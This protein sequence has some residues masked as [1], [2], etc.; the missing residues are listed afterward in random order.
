MKRI[1]LLAAIKSE[2]PDCIPY[3]RSNS[4][5]NFRIGQNDIGVLLSGVGPEK[6][7]KTTE[8]LCA[9]FK[10]DLII[11]LGFCG[12]IDPEL[13]I[14]TL[15]VADTIYYQGKKEPLDCSVSGDVKRCL[16]NSSTD[17]ITGRFQTFDHPVLSRKEVLEGVLGVDMEAYAICKMAQKFN[18]PTSIIKSV[19]DFLPAEKPLI[20]PQMRLLFRILRN[21][22]QAKKSLNALGRNYFL[23]QNI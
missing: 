6:A 1:G 13:H 12:C 11:A 22:K 17:F 18:I 20:F 8:K 15:I 3:K 4:I 19:S 14:G 2:I 7:E 5:Q 10:P 23:S 16:I 9:E 21:F